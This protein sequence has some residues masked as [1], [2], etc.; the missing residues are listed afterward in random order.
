MASVIVPVSAGVTIKSMS[1][2]SPARPRHVGISLAWRTR[3]LGSGAAA[4]GLLA[5]GCFSFPPDFP[6]SPRR[7]P[8][9]TVLVSANGRVITAVGGKAC[10]HKP[11][12]VA[13]SHPDKVTQ[14]W[15]NPDATC[16]AETARAVAVRI[17][18]PEPLG[19]RPLAH[20][21]GSGRIPY[22]SQRDF[23]RVTV[24]PAGYRLSSEV[25]AGQP[26]GDRRT[27]TIPP[28]TDTA[29]THRP[30]PCAQLVIWQQVLSRG[31][32]SPTQQTSQ[33]PIHAEVHGRSAALLVN[34]PLDAR[35]VNWA[36]HGYYFTVG[37]AYGPDIAP[38]TNTQL[39]AVADGI[40]PRPG[41]S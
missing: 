17:V 18:L 20:A 27:Y 40:Q 35:S 22:F 30:C 1:R 15:V 14:V 12:L 34:G 24:L 41:T 16:N 32:I 39:I 8:V 19:N 21:S 33:H 25:P 26:V 13:R 11:R 6:H 3:R 23:A 28:G 38:L 31:F 10:G 2:K 5:A 7:F 9:A 29:G 36:E 37:V 4:L